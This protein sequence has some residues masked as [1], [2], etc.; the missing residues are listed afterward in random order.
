[1][2]ILEIPVLKKKEEEKR[3]GAVPPPFLLR[4][5]GVQL[6]AGTPRI[7][8]TGLWSLFWGMNGRGG[9]VAMA[10][11]RL[12]SLIAMFSGG[13]LAAL[14]AAVLATLAIAVASFSQLLNAGGEQVRGW[15]FERR[16]E[17]PS[18]VASAAEATRPDMSSLI[19]AMEGPSETKTDAPKAPAAE[20][21]KEET[22]Q[23]PEPAAAD[24][25]AQVKEM[26]DAMVGESPRRL[27]AGSLGAGATGRSS[28][29][30]L[31]DSLNSF[32]GVKS[33]GTLPAMKELGR[34]TPPVKSAA[35][36]PLS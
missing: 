34:L 31:R 18:P 23:A 21:K 15:S 28:G 12:R 1:M 30:E 36:N 32:N 10:L 16:E 25:A 33:F 17:A 27:V 19:G 11:A 13:E 24:P 35:R 6:A 14:T 26:V 22:T 8:G 2:E 3:G 4:T 20:T 7:G 9:L 29:M 5:A